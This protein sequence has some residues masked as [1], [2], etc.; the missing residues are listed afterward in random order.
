MRMLESE[1]APVIPVVSHSWGHA[2]TRASVQ[3]RAF[4]GRACALL[5]EKGQIQI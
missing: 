1:S 3:A 5:A 4:K 2:E